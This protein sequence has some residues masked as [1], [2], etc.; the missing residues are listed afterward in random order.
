MTRARQAAS[1]AV[2]LALAL[3]A[4]HGEPK[5]DR[6]VVVDAQASPQA[7][8]EPAPLTSVVAAASATEGFDAGPPPSVLRGDRA[9]DTDGLT[10]IPTS[11]ALVAQLQ[12]L[13]PPAAVHGPELNA[14]AVDAKRKAQDLAFAI[15]LA[16]ARMRL[17]FG[18][19]FIIPAGIELRARR[20]YYGFLLLDR[21]GEAY[22]VLAP[23]A[24]R[25]LFGERRVD[26]SPLS[27]SGQTNAGEGTKRLGLRTRK[28]E[29]TTRAAKATVELAR[30]PEL[31]EGGVLLARVIL[32]LIS[33]PPQTS[34]ATTDEIPLHAELHWTTHG[35][36]VFDVTSL[37]RRTD[38]PVA[39]LL[40]PPPEASFRLAPLASVA[41]ELVLTP[42]ELAALHTGPVDLQSAA[43]AQGTLNVYNA[44]DAPRVLWLDGVRVGW[45]APDTRLSI[46][47]LQRGHYQ[48][49]SRTYLDD[50]AEPPRTVTAPGEVTIGGADAGAG[51]A[52]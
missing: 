48:L 10:Q 4:C 2:A 32:D 25:A 21:T 38:A 17:V 43:P 1:F 18:P 12:A 41:G 27:T 22:R 14:A 20:D 44:T 35:G 37:A 52:R 51:G 24:L 28:V 16:P 19:G 46:P 8:A 40:A 3:A 49:E 31:G 34:L 29:I 36:I 9:L 7:K 30:V 13:E 15:E 50:A 6:P 23:G 45:V 47:S 39:T 33:A 26:V 5:N 42:T 11:F